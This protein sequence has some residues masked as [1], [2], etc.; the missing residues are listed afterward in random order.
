MNYVKF[1]LTVLVCISF[2]AVNAQKLT[3]K[4]KEREANKVEIFTSEEKDN[5]QMWFHEETKKL[6]LSEEESERYR[7]IIANNVYK[8]RRLNDKDSK[9]T[10]EEVTTEFKKL[11]EKTNFEVKD[12]LSEEQY[13]MHLKNFNKLANSA[14]KRNAKKN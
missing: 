11:V 5:M 12:V 1:V 2:C 13:E 8:M 9:L 3:E 4:Q 7:Q 6:N 14:L 10:E